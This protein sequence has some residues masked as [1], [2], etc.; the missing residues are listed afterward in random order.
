MCVIRK[1]AAPAASNVTPSLVISYFAHAYYVF[2]AGGC[3]DTD[4]ATSLTIL[5]SEK[6][7]LHTDH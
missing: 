1:R 6:L 2:I 5:A 3:K 4:A 7:Y